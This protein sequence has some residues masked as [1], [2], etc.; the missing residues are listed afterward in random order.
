MS[1]KWFSMLN[2]R[3]TGKPQ[4]GF[5]LKPIIVET[6]NQINNFHPFSSFSNQKK[7]LQPRFSERFF[8]EEM[9]PTID[10]VL[11]EVEIFNYRQ[12]RGTI[13]MNFVSHNEHSMAIIP[14]YIDAKMVIYIRGKSPVAEFPLRIPKQDLAHGYFLDFETS[15][16]AEN[17]LHTVFETILTEEERYEDLHFTFKIAIIYNGL[18]IEVL[19]LEKGKLSSR[20]WTPFQKF[21]LTKGWGE[22][23]PF[24][25]PTNNSLSSDMLSVLRPILAGSIR[26]RPKSR[27]FCTLGGPVGLTKATPA[28]RAHEVLERWSRCRSNCT[29]PL[30]WC[31][32]DL[33]S[34]PN[35]RRRQ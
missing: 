29:W 13:K 35:S 2:I 1:K 10:G 9:W 17:G 19:R 34:A 3:L 18:L 8:G 31:R 12:L 28:V 5:W 33:I 27:H 21:L 22:L 25:N 24:R 23:V 11:Q 32:G 4:V 6:H 30:V 20:C 15:T 26:Y 16:T 14:D 7:N